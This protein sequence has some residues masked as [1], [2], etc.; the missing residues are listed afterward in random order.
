MY[1]YDKVVKGVWVKDPINGVDCR[2][3][4]AIVDGKIAAIEAD[5]PMVR[6]ER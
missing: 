4:I 2:A 1:Q 5:I 6:E 3:D